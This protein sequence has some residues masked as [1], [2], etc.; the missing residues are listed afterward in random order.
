MHHTGIII[1]IHLL[2]AIT[3]TEIT[4][5]IEQHNKTSVEGSAITVSHH[6]ASAYR[7]HCIAMYLFTSMV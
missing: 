1:I 6:P 3:Q 5:Y 4:E 7:N 2:F